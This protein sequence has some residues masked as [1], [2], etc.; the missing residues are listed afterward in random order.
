M[1]RE[2]LAAGHPLSEFVFLTRLGEPIRSKSSFERG[3]FHRVVRLAGLTR[4]M[5]VWTGT[6]FIVLGVWSIWFGLFVSIR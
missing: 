1:Q 3:V 5:P 2:A 4:R 6:L